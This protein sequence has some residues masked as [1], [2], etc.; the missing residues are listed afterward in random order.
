MLYMILSTEALPTAQCKLMSMTHC[1]R[2]S[3]I[4]K[5]PLRSTSFDRTTIPSNSDLTIFSLSWQ[6]IVQNQITGVH[7]LETLRMVVNAL[8]TGTW[9]M[10]KLSNSIRVI[11]TLQAQTLAHTRSVPFKDVFFPFV[12]IVFQ[13]LLG[14]VLLLSLCCNTHALSPGARSLPQSVHVSVAVLAEISLMSP[15]K[16]FIF[17]IKKKYYRIKV[18][19]K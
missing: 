5:M 15:Q 13:P 6:Y 12:L 8:H 2:S 9:V 4:N 3:K 18:S 11:T 1:M 10:S 16:I 7:V 17:I 14:A 19:K